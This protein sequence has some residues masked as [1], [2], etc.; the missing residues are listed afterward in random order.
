MMGAGVLKEG[1]PKA[2]AFGQ[3]P[4]GGEY[5]RRTHMLG[6]GGHRIPGPGNRLN[7]PSIPN[8]LLRTSI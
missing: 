5:A 8:S 7:L 3:R 6:V 2:G 1:L 4:A